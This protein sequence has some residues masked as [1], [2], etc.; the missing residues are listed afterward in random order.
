M[1]FFAIAR[2]TVLLLIVASALAACGA[3]NR[4]DA[5]EVLPVDQL[6]DLA[7]HSMDAGNY[8]RAA[9]LYKRLVGRFPYGKYSEQGQI[10]LA[11]AQYKSENPDE[12]LSSINRFIKL[13]PTHEHADYAWYL[14]ALINFDRE[15]GL[16]ERYIRTDN[17]QRDLG[18]SRQSFQDFGELIKRYPQ[19]PYASDAR[20]RMIF[21]RNNI[22]QSELNIAKYYF[23]REAYVAVQTRA[24][25]I[26][27]NYQETPQA[28]DALALMAESYKRLGQKQLSDD[29]LRV[30]KLNYP[31]HPY[32]SGHWPKRGN[33]F[34]QLVPLF[35]EQRVHG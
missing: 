8:D 33:L 6:Y 24:K 32:L 3:K 23:R 29:S 13:Y 30:L 16:L 2:R 14:R 5:A 19:S 10:D 28:G 26:I 15:A 31:D 9:K 7:K 1:T 34:W 11:Y 17:T 20:Q 18:F 27:E 4:T 12:A 21:L 25:Y 35:G 22:A